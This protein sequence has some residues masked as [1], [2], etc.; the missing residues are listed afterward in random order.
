MFFPTPTYSVISITGYND[1]S[2]MPKNHDGAVVVPWH[3]GRLWI[4]H[5]RA[6]ICIFILTIAVRGVL[7]ALT[8]SQDIINLGQSPMGLSSFEEG[9]NVALS[10][11]SG[12]GFSNPYA[13]ATGSTS[14]LPPS[15]PAVTALIYSTFGTGLAGGIIRNLLNITA[16]GV[17]FSLFPAASAALG[18]GAQA[19]T[20]A[21]IGAAIFPFY[22]A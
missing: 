10:L 3:P 12:H 9:L 15:F 2:E 14:H 22:R 1:A 4:S 5:R 11:A 20:I 19:G 16:Y 21:G 8:P 7:L 17:L 18:L 13:L 6:A